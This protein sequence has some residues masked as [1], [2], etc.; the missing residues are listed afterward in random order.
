M[1]NEL[2][3][4]IEDR[5]MTPFQISAVGIC[6]VLN[7]LDGFDVLAIAFTAPGIS[8]EWNVSPQSLGLLFSA[9]P[10]GM[11]LGALFL[12]PVADKIGRRSTVLLCLGIIT[13]GMLC[14]ALTNGV[15]QLFFFRVFTG[16]GIGGILPSLNTIVAEYS[17]NRRRDL[18]ISFMH[19]GYPIGAAIGGSISAVLLL[20]YGWRSVFVLGGVMSA[21]ML[22]V[23]YWRLPDSLDFLLAKQPKNA[24][25]K[26]NRVLAGLKHQALTE[27]PARNDEEQQRSVGVAFVLSD[28]M[29]VSSL[30]LWSAFFLTLFSM[31][32]LQSWIPQILVGAGF[33]ANEGITASVFF[34]FGGVAGGLALGYASVW[35][36][37]GTRVR[38]FLFMTAVFMV[39]F[40]IFNLGY[41]FLLA[42][43]AVIGFFV[44]GSIIGLYAV[45][46]RI[47]P[48]AVRATGIAWGIGIGRLGAIAGPYTA[49][50]LIGSG[51]S[52]T[53]S[54]VFFATIL[55]LAM[56]AMFFLNVPTIEGDSGRR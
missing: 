36:G 29:R 30:L 32:F 2:T 53:F 44:F 12:G 3:R 52:I 4:V 25:E 6:L 48:T 16:L 28:K 27:V 31:F 33:S 46:P 43:A 38:V 7:M 15:N 37:L 18:S 26:I 10:I 49:G 42:C 56:L 41:L 11:A 50:I 5:P 17:S 39:A 1:S 22:L 55:L 34:S 51:F 23:V 20:Q 54:F 47:Y 19:V 45:A 40:V 21:L 9:A 13:V 24:L 8:E 14:S 35:F